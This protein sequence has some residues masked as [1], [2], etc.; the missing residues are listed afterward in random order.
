MKIKGNK[1]LLDKKRFKLLEKERI[2]ELKSLTYE[3]SALMV[4]QLLDFANEFRANFIS[5]EEHHGLK[6]YLRRKNR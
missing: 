6:W 4:E 1:G 5:E 2:K 3:Q